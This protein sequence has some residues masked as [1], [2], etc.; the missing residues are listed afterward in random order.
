MER[1]ARCGAA[2]RSKWISCTLRSA[3]SLKMHRLMVVR[4][5]VP[6]HRLEEARFA[7]RSRL[8][9]ISLVI[10]VVAGGVSL[11]FF[12]T[13][14][15]RI[16]RLKEFSRRVADG[17]FR[18]LPLERS[19]DELAQL[20]NTLGQTAV[21]LDRT[22]KTLTEERNRSAAVLAS[23]EEGVAVDRERSAGDLLQQRFLPGRGHCQP[24]L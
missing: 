20:S 21:K 23:M 18:P 14:S 5:S 24:V 22:I 8:W 17:D 12:R 2:R 13:V 1:G 19:K 3:M 11:L 4:L 6:L 15:R 9:G 16:G 7:F 10:L